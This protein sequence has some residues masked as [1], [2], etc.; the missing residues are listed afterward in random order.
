MVA[1]PPGPKSFFFMHFSAKFLQNIRLTHRFW[2]LAL[3]RENPGSTG[4]SS[5]RLDPLHWVY[6]AAPLPLENRSPSSFKRQEKR[7][8]LVYGDMPLPLMLPLDARC[9]P[10]NEEISNHEQWV[11][12]EIN[13][14]DEN[15]EYQSMKVWHSSY[16]RPLFLI[17]FVQ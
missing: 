14:N 5:V 3:L 10:L 1:H 11:Q 7:L 8:M 2:E 12:D 15:K 9:V 4:A 16:L 17:I 13:P 6:C